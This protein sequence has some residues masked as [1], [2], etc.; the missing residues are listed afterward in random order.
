[1]YKKIMALALALVL[2]LSLASCNAAPTLSPSLGADEGA[3][4]IDELGELIIDEDDEDELIDI[5]DGEVPL[6]EF[7]MGGTDAVSIT[8]ITIQM[9]AN[10]K[11]GKKVTPQITVTPQNASAKSVVLSVDNSSLMQINNSGSFNVIGAGRCTVTATAPGGVTA[12]VTVNI[13]DFAAFEAEVLKLMNDERAKEGL[14]AMSAANKKLKEAADIRA[15][16]LLSSFSHTRP[17][18]EKCF[19]AYRE[20]G[21]SYKAA[22]ENI[23]N[24]YKT[25]S[26]VVKGW[27][28]SAG[29]RKNI[30][31][32]TYSQ[33]GISVDIDESGKLFW[34]QN[35]IG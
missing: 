26:D 19:S 20:C 27:M 31:S 14:P 28:N 1:M 17:N 24:G 10:L 6:A 3:T 15:A 18:G 2:A 7:P 23:A 34:T 21:V 25:P 22:G 13:T 16:E 29:H 5:E 33:V 12:S 35:F 9:P 30:M 11:V 8:G 32:D 4:D